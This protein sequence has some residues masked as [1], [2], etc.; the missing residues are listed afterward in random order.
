MIAYISELSTLTGDKEMGFPT[1]KE[2]EKTLKD[3]KHT[4]GTLA[5][6]PKA[7]ALEKFRFN[8]CQS[9]L[10]YKQEKNLTQR[11]FA[12]ILKVDE[13]KVSKILHHRIKEFSTDRLINLY[14][15]IDPEIEIRFA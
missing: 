1:K 4:E 11:K 2:I 8:L 3:L 9:F 14:L 5:L 6:S 12:E 15:I 13:A 7:T 10:K